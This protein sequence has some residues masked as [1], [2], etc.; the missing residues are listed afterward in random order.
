MIDD[1]NTFM[2]CVVGVWF[3]LCATLGSSVLR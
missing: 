1:P 2:L 3:V